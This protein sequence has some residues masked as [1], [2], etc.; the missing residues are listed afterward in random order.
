MLLGSGFA[1]GI[2]IGLALSQEPA[3][4]TQTTDGSR[5]ARPLVDPDEPPAGARPRA[6]PTASSRAAVWQ[7]LPPASTPVVEVFDELA[8][9]ARAGDAVAAR[10]LGDDL[11][12][13]RTVGSDA[14]L[15]GPVGGD[16]RENGAA[17]PRLSAEEQRLLAQL[18]AQ[19]DSERR[20]AGAEKLARRAADWIALAARNGDPAAMLCYT[21]YPRDWAPNLL[22]P[23]WQ[24]HA[25]QAFTLAPQFARRAFDAGMPEAAAVLSRM[26]TA[27]DGTEAG[28]RWMGRLGADPYWAYAYALVA[29]DTLP[30]AR[31]A[32][33][34]ERSAALV[35]PLST[36]ERARARSWA[37]AQRSRMKLPPAPEPGGQHRGRGH[38]DCATLVYLGSRH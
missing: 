10:R 21:L 17:T 19:D 16:P 25:E 26:Y 18:A 30:G 38:R 3:I 35:L 28:G 8:A 32:L 24:H 2:V 11:Q 37:D 29:A 34:G 5:V 20:C 9:R 31:R 7:S 22:S 23:G 14:L 4:P 33:W 15:A 12:R 1:M 27:P 13:C 6:S 36:D